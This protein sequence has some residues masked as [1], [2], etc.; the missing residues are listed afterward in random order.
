MKSKVK[1]PSLKKMGL[2][3]KPHR[4]LLKGLELAD[5]SR[6][7]MEEAFKS[8]EHPLESPLFCA[9]WLTSL[10]CL[11]FLPSIWTKPLKAHTLMQAI[12]GAN[13][14]AEGK[15]NGLIVDYCGILK[16][17]RKALATFAGAGDE[18]HG[19]GEGENEPAKP[20]EELLESLN[21]SISFV[22]EFLR[23][24][25][26]ELNRI[27]TETGFAKNAAIA[28]ARKSSIKMTKHG[29]RFEGNDKRGVQQV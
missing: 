19:G 22:A 7:D 24:H 26:F 13:R 21:E 9:M 29:K 2:D 6:L 12:A 25:D 3:I 15:N 18:G 10:M 23:K 16:N 11:H 28:Q 5:G 27:I 1:S 20:N 17:L 8:S 4:Q 14:V